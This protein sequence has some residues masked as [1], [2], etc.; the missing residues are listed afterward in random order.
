MTDIILTVF[1]LVSGGFPPKPI[2]DVSGTL[3]A[4]GLRDGDV[5]NIKLL[6]TPFQK[7]QQPVQ[8][9]PQQQ[10][11]TTSQSDA[12]ETANGLLVVRVS[13]YVK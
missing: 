1:A 3:S 13:K 10:P 2:T 6:D 9:Q 11:Q 8:Q 7:A 4:A 12:V 5:L